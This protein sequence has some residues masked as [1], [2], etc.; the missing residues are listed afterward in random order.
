MPYDLP[1]PPSVNR[2]VT[3]EFLFELYA[4]I[5][6]LKRMRE[7]ARDFAEEVLFC[8]DYG[9]GAGPGQCLHG[10]ARAFLDALG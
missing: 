7:L 8:D 5:E 10:R 4:E 3:L 6:Q 9:C 1:D 2:T